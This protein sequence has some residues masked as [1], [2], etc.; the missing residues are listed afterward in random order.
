MNSEIN[1]QNLCFVVNGK[2]L[3]THGQQSFKR[4]IDPYRVPSRIILASHLRD[5]KKMLKDKDK[6]MQII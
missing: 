6:S 1:Q 3:Y 4:M 2:D 5:D